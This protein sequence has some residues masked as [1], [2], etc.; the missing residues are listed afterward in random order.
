MIIKLCSRCRVFENKRRAWYLN[1]L[2]EWKEK[3]KRIITF[4]NNNNQS[5]RAI[6]AVDLAN[7]FLEN[8]KIVIS[9]DGGMKHVLLKFMTLYYLFL[10]KPRQFI[11]FHSQHRIVYALC[12]IEKKNFYH[13]NTH[14]HCRGHL[15]M[16]QNNPIRYRNNFFFGYFKETLKR[17]N[18]LF[19]GVTT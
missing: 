6:C 9:L 3:E 8:R 7:L 1:S 5:S 18:T 13:W 16:C 19:L 17:S 15:K 14:K 11:I 10:Y 12:F 2:P 4:F